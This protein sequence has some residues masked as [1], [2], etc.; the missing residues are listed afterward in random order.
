MVFDDLENR[1]K[2]GKKSERNYEC[3]NCGSGIEGGE[4][5]YTSGN[6]KSKHGRKWFNIYNS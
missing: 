1:W 5:V 2:Q 3:D 6:L 4:D